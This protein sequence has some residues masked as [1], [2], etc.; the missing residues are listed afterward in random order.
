M[1]LSSLEYL[2]RFMFEPPLLTASLDWPAVQIHGRGARFRRRRSC[3]IAIN[4]P[5]ICLPFG[6]SLSRIFRAFGV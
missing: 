5:Q 3:L 2:E 4:P 6:S 1:R